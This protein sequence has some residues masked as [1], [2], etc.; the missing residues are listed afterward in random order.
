[1]SKH[2]RGSDGLRRGSRSRHSND[3]LRD[4]DANTISGGMGERKTTSEES[5]HGFADDELESLSF[6]GPRTPK[7]SS[8]KCRRC[9][10]ELSTKARYC[11]RCYEERE[12]WM[13]LRPTRQKRRRPRNEQSQERPSNP[14]NSVRSLDRGTDWDRL[15]NPVATVQKGPRGEGMRLPDSN[16]SNLPQFARERKYS[17]SSVSSDEFRQ[18]KRREWMKRRAYY[19]RWE[20][21]GADEIHW[22]EVLPR[23]LVCKVHQVDAY[24]IHGSTAHACVCQR[25]A[26]ALLER[27]GR[28]LQCHTKATGV[29]KKPR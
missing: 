25:C 8:N 3:S 4:M 2:G 7:T 26:M 21:E 20:G 15:F 23:C 18:V 5:R 29:T 1:M 6:V 27:Q 17:T 19:F 16:F 24:I 28:C 22:G 14:R 9:Q 10:A 12:K 13:P 11:R